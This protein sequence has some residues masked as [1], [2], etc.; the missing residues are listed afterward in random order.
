MHSIQ[1]LSAAQV[2]SRFF[3]SLTSYEV[4]KIFNWSEIEILAKFCLLLAT[5]L[6]NYYSSS[7]LLHASSSIVNKLGGDIAPIWSKEENIPLVI[8]AVCALD[9]FLND[10]GIGK[11]DA[12]PRLPGNPAILR[13]LLNIF[14]HYLSLVL[15]QIEGLEPRHIEPLY[16]LTRI[17]NFLEQ[18]CVQIPEILFSDIK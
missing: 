3:K 14:T 17:V 5:K 12:Q 13:Y 8:Q 2:T 9:H 11:S 16:Q 4:K 7:I 6:G 1:I 18:D 15:E 10:F